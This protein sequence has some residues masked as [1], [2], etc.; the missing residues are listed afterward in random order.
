MARKI[1]EG[2]NDIARKTISAYGGV[3]NAAR[4]LI[5]GYIG[6]NNK[7]RLFWAMFKPIPN[8][9]DYIDIHTLPIKLVY[10][11]GEVIDITGIVVYGYDNNDN[12]VRQIPFE[13]LLHTPVASPHTGITANCDPSVTGSS[14]AI[15]S[16]AGAVISTFTG[17]RSP[18]TKLNSG[19]AACLIG[20]NVMGTGWGGNWC[21][22]FG[23]SDVQSAAIINMPTQGAGAG[24]ATINNI[25]YYVSGPASNASW[26][27]ATPNT[28]TNPLD[29]P[30]IS[31]KQLNYP[32]GSMTIAQIKFIIRYTNI[33]WVGG[34]VTVYTYRE[35]GKEL[36]C[37]YGI[38]VN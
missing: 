30:V 15:V 18:V 12:F 17:N 31:D 10:E 11:D 19:D 32:N 37:Q 7:A 28:I 35:D 2:V 21:E 29:L 26:G 34:A 36:H 27:G 4:K 13:S 8:D 1:Y 6:V 33:L 23:I 38:T 25:D 20:K 24:K 16:Q 22:F 3:D 14:N 5:K 9:V